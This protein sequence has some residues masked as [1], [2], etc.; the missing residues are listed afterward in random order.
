MNISH[1]YTLRKFS[2]IGWWIVLPLSAF[3]IGYGFKS[4]AMHNV[5]QEVVV[6]SQVQI[7]QAQE[8]AGEAKLRVAELKE[9]VATLE[10][11]K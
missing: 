1:P 9:K 6:S 3:L 5:V 8:K 7:E 10:G 2:M 11:H 4:L